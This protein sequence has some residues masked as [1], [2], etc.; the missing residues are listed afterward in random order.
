MQSGNEN[1]YAFQKYLTLTLFALG[2]IFVLRLMSLWYNNSE[3]YFDEAQYWFWSQDPAFGYF[4]KP[5]VLA[6]IIAI[7][8][9]ICGSDHSFCVRLSAPVIHTATAAMLFLIAHRLFNAQVAFW[10]ALLY[11][12]MPAVSL[13]STII[14]TDIALLFFWSVALYCYVRLIEEHDLKWGLALGIALGLAVNAKYAAVYFLGCALLHAWIEQREM[15]PP[16]KRPF[17]LAMA[18]AA[19]MLIPNIIWNLHNSFVTVSHT[20]E[21]I[22]WSGVNPNWSGLAEFFGSQFG[23]FGPI[24]F[25]MFIATVIRM[26]RDSISFKHRFLLVFSVPII[27]VILF[28]AVISKAYANWAAVTYIAATLLVAE[29]LVNRVPHAWLK[30]STALHSMMAGAIAIAVCFAAPGQLVLPNGAQ[31]FARTQGASEIADIVAK[32]LDLKPYDAVLTFDRKL[33]A[34]LAYNL[35]DRKEL[36]Q[37]WRSNSPRDHFQLV[38]A[39]QDNPQET[40]LLVARY[41]QVEGIT[42]KF[43]QVENLGARLISAGET[44]SITL[45]R[46]S[47]IIR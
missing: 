26:M 20:G 17:W 15:T 10:A 33:S 40:V 6:W 16:R 36:K 18:V 37:A 35:R 45:Y 39:F 14:S 46:L 44:G 47:G 42:G 5:P 21:N 27:S 12:T 4:S 41:D 9:E 34:L 25:G 43:K 28:Q 31:P 38:S 30:T 24:L 11:A 29:I 19:M 32:E 23:V 8:T 3:L 1:E 7:T 2:G 13:S 22:G